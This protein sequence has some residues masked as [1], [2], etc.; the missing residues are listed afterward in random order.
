MI[1]PDG[2]HDP[3]FSVATLQLGEIHWYLLKAA[4]MIA[5]RTHVMR[6]AA[7]ALGRA[8][9]TEPEPTD[10]GKEVGRDEI[11][12]WVWR[13]EP[14]VG[15]L[16]ARTSQALAACDKLKAASA[17]LA[18]LRPG[19]YGALIESL[20]KFA[21][22]HQS[23][24]E[25]LH[26]YVQWLHGKHVLAPSLLFT[27]RVWGSTRR[28]DRWASLDAD[29][30]SAETS[31][32]IRRLAEMVLGLRARGLYAYERAH[33]EIGADIA[34]EMDPES[35]S[36]E[37]LIPIAAVV[38]QASAQAYRECAVYFDEVRQS[39]RNVL[40][41]IDKFIEERGLM[42]ND[43]FWRGFIEKAARAGTAE[44]QLWDFKEALTLWRAPAG[45]ERDK[46]GVVF[47]ED[48]ASLANARGGV[49]IIGV[50]D[51]H[52]RRIVGIGATAREVED[53]LKV[54][55]DVVA[56][57][58]QCDGEAVS[59]RQVLLPDSGGTERI[60]LAVVVAQTGE[61]VAVSD[62]RGK[63]TYPVRRETGI[64]RVAPHDLVLAKSHVK[65]DNHDFLRELAQF[66][67]SP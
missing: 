43:A 6:P 31:A 60:C 46:A 20:R 54:A 34:S 49:L 19:S 41:D 1:L 36:T 25:S 2:A 10:F 18:R 28:G 11:H 21:D 7:G 17:D 45:A 67:S 58:L 42:G 52:P 16:K 51:K 59:F 5:D 47:A 64:E 27:Y 63:Y 23:E 55:R 40:L 15:E 26:G 65:G 56:M 61:V 38:S 4:T 9:F 30:P 12:W 24:I 66:A 39:L 13:R 57:H 8:G 3:L 14:N 62:G 33:M 37:I 50:T 44:P 22:T 29:T 32:A 35:G 48:I 53:R